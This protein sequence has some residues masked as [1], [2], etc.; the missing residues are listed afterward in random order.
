[1]PKTKYKCQH[2]LKEKAWVW[3]DGSV[4]MVKSIDC[5]SREPKF[6]VQY[7]HDNLQASVTQSQGILHSLLASVGPG[8]CMVLRQNTHTH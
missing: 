1:M 7:P 6:S 2:S 5:L 4:V 3:R 8:T